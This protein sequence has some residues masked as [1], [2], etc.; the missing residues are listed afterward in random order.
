MIKWYKLIKWINSQRA[1]GFL[2]FRV[3]TNRDTFII[4]NEDNKESIRLKY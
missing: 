3:V 1:K 4:W 2:S